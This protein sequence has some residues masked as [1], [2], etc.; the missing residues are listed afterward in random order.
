MRPRYGLELIDATGVKSGTLY[1]LLGRLAEAGW[2]VAT[3][4]TVDTTAVGRPAR[5]Y[6][7]LTGDGVLE[8]KNALAALRRHG[9][10]G[11]SP[12]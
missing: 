4:E 10:L 5:T 9:S 6:Y 12:A 3:R 7:Q 8:A 2:L 1:P 11:W